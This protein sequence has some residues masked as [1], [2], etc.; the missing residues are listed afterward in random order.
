MPVHLFGQIAPMARL[1]ELSAA[2][3]VALVEDAAQSHGAMQDGRHA[4]SLGAIAGTSFYPGKNLGA[5]GDAGAV[6][7]N[8]AGLA[9]FVV[10]SRNHGRTAGGDHG[11]FGFNS[12]LDTLQAVVL[13]AKLGYLDEWNRERRRAAALYGE[14]LAD[15]DEV[16][17]PV[18]SRGNVHVWHI[19]GIRVAERD[20]VLAHL[21]AAGIGA[22]IHYP[23]P[24]HLQS[25]FAPLGLAAG[26]LPVAERAA[27]EL[28][29]LPIF[30]GITPAQQ[31]R[32]RD[33]LIKA[34]R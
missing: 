15:V 29:S 22:T 8:D 11:A 34:I 31:E 27:A 18:T 16:R 24:I 7:T 9:D 4:G 17:L 28:L 13:R 10:A 6:L 2:T 19:Y 33:E 23:V 5:Y 3:G 14:L 32:V 1:L 20:R 30:P 21:N 26:T 12:R 25:A